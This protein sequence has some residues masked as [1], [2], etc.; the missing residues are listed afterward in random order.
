MIQPASD[1]NTV[2]ITPNFTPNPLTVRFAVSR[3]LLV[4]SGRDFPTRDTADG[5]PLPER[6]FANPDIQSVYVGTDFVTITVSPGD[7]PM[8]HAEFVIDAIRSHT[9]AGEPAVSTPAA[10]DDGATGDARGTT[11]LER[12]IIEAIDQRVRPA[13][14]MDGGDIVF[15]GLEAGVVQLQLRGAC[16]GCPS[17]TF[18]LKMGI[19]NLLKELFP[20]DVLAVEAV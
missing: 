11:D 2:Q 3:Q 18:T 4:G 14:A 20:G 15:A 1:A 9:A 19:E 7:S 16:S 10:G 8:A 17:S 13:V 6:L 5:S 12:Q